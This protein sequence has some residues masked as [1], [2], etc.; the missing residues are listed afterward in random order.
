MNS[1]FW[2]KF[3]P[4]WSYKHLE[5]IIKCRFLIWKKTIWWIHPGSICSQ[6]KSSLFPGPPSPPS[7]I[8]RPTQSHSQAHPVS[9]PD[10]PSFLPGPSLAWHG[11]AGESWHISCE[12]DVIQWQKILWMQKWHFVCCHTNYMFKWY[13]VWPTTSS[14]VPVFHFEH[15]LLHEPLSNE[16]AH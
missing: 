12:H 16:L 7:L 13:L 8:P 15:T 14:T 9:F 4:P 3:L 1:K 2:Q 5:E 10:P 11:K 6:Q